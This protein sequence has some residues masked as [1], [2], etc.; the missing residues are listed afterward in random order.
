MIK[1]INDIYFGNTKYVDKEVVYTILLLKSIPFNK[2][3]ADVYWNNR[4]ESIPTNNTKNVLIEIA[5]IHP[6]V[7]GKPGKEFE[8]HLLQ[9]MEL[10]ELEKQKGNNPII[11]IPGSLRYIINKTTNEME[12]EAMPLAEAGKKFLIS[13]G[14]P[15]NII[16]ANLSNIEFKGENGV[17]NS[18][19]EC[20]VATQI[21][22]KEN[23]GRIISVVSPVQIY[24]KA[25]FYNEFGFNPEIYATGTEK[26]AHNYIGEIFWSLYLTY[27][28]DQDWQYSFLSFLTRKERNLDFSNKII[29]YKDIV[30][31]ILNNSLIVL[32]VQ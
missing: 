32:L 19:D 21:A 11:Y 8:E 31:D 10:Y 25:L 15:E 27:M 1:K 28:N 6:L 9:G 4:Y 30:T 26:T 5:A 7:D 3:E 23:C 12:V 18:A 17:Y 29:D 16:R 2:Q 20:Y 22:K 13:H 14:I 24:R